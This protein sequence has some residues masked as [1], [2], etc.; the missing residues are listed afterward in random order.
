MVLN[1]T[2]P[3]VG[4]GAGKPIQIAL[5]GDFVIRLAPPLKP[6]AESNTANNRLRA[7]EF[8]VSRGVMIAHSVFFR[9]L[10]RVQPTLTIISI[11][12]NPS[13]IKTALELWLR[14]IHNGADSLLPSLQ[15]EHS[16]HVWN[17]M[18]VGVSYASR[19]D[20]RLRH[21]LIVPLS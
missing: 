19:T 20:T 2:V 14:A 12:D 11:D 15:A 10:F 5:N 6:L 17:A 21:M 18:A 7:V 16:R 13:G 4:A 3:A 1:C 8:R 9:D